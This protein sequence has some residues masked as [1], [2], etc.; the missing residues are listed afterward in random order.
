MRTPLPIDPV[1]AEIRAALERHRAVVVTA[2]P[3]AGKTTRVPPALIDRGPVLV[4]Q[5]RRVAARAIARR[6]AE[7]QGWTLGREVGWHVRFDRHVSPDTQ[8]IVATEGVL[9]ARL[10]A[11]PLLS[12]LAT[13]VLDEFHE[14]SIHADLG[15]ALARHAW[16]ARDDLRL[17][18]MSA[19]MDPEPVAAFLGGCPVVTAPGRTHAVEIQYAPGDSLPSVAAALTSTRAGATLC[20]L[21]GAREIAEAQQALAGCGVPVFPLHGQL[22]LQAQEAALTPTGGPRIVLATN[23]AE[24]TVTVPDVVTVVDSGWQKVA[25]YDPN[26]G[27]DVLVRERVSVDAA[28]QRAG[29][30]GRTQSGRVVRLWDSRD[31]LRATREP[32]ILR[33][34]LAS[35]AL[36]VLAWGEDPRRFS[37]FESPPSWAL[38]A[39]LE[40]LRRL[41]AVDSSGRLTALGQALRQIPLH[42]RLGRVLLAAGA[43]E[44]AALVCAWL[45][46]GGRSPWPP[47]TASGDSD[48]DSLTAAGTPPFIREAARQVHQRGREALER[49]PADVR[50]AVV[51]TSLRRAVLAGYPDR[52]ARRREA[53]SPRCLLAS[54]T[55]AVLSRDSVVTSA[56]WFVAL[57]VNAQSG[58]STTRGRPPQE[59]MV[60]RASAVDP[61]WVTPTHSEAV[62]WFDAEAGV[63]RAARR[64][65]VDAIPLREVGLA[66][67]PDQAA[68]C[69]A[70]AWLSRTADDERR[71]LERRVA[72]AQIEVD[73][74]SVAQHAAAGLTRIGD[75]RIEE[76]VPADVRAALARHA[77]ERLVVPSGRSIPLTYRDDGAVVAAVKLQELFGLAD[78]PRL[79]PRQVP[80]TFELLAPNQRPVQVTQDLRSFWSRGYP[81]VRRL[82][83]ARYPKHPWPEDP[84]TAVPTH[85]TRR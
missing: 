69:L 67:D 31:R 58:A 19:T 46:D 3:G 49:L 21:P 38:Q 26:R 24:T 18:V 36:E 8:V 59:A 5:P 64:D 30:A 15:L 6:I 50:D 73:W 2:A 78:T 82:L 42:P 81:E 76:A 32:E 47:P 33:V 45:S 41:G 12:D 79:G 11:D 65:W 85:R 84:W 71:T 77:P 20:F 37:W 7:E 66:P 44:H 56:E 22:E 16:V 1:V 57:E 35:P 29:R 48:L 14:R 53:G 40:L 10:Q 34:D 27:V 63:V 13:V 51:E 39:A 61:E 60:R 80:V 62:H 23:V 52:L 75:L 54:G 68:Q 4:L 17:V 43:T 25:R 74:V 28:D 70:E 83:R 55:G 72:F 9:T